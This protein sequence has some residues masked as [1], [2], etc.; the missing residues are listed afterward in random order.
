[1][2]AQRDTGKSADHNSNRKLSRI[3]W[4]GAP[5]EIMSSIAA[6]TSQV[7]KAWYRT[8]SPSLLPR[9][10]TL[11]MVQELA[12]ASPEEPRLSYDKACLV[13]GCA[14]RELKDTFMR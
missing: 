3:E 7:N 6:P 10:I 14:I 4:S 8:F 12:D 11:I 2:Y 13:H 1:M 9:I 5:I